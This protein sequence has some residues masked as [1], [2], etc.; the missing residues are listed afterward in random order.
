MKIDRSKFN[1]LPPELLAAL[2]KTGAVVLPETFAAPSVSAN[3]AKLGVTLIE[4]G[5]VRETGSKAGEAY[6]S[7]CLKVSAE[8][9]ATLLVLPVGSAAM[10]ERAKRISAALAA[11]FA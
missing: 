10:L 3:A 4:A 6:K 7:A 5:T 9:G 1:N 2:A 11:Y 8:S